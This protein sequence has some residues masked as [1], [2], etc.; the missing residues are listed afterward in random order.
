MKSPPQ[1]AAGYLKDCSGK[2]PLGSGRSDGH[3][4]QTNKVTQ[5]AAGD[6]VP[7]FIVDCRAISVQS[8]KECCG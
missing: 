4:R 7:D 3:W 8:A 6:A 5:Q 1:Q 2:P